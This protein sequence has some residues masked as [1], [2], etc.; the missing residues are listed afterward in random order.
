[1]SANLDALVEGIRAKRSEKLPQAKARLE[2]LKA[3]KQSVIDAKSKA[4]LVAGSS[5]ELQANLYG[6]PYDQ[7]VSMLDAAI[8]AS[9]NAVNR[10]RRESINIGVAGMAGQG[11]SQILQMLTG[12][13]DKQIPTGDGGY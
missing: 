5:S 12:L 4:K 10:L 7:T 3:A 8:E 6:L 11:K 13:G 9:E 1:M 2:K